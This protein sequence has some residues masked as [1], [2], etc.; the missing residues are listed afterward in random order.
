VHSFLSSYSEEGL[1]K[2]HPKVRNIICSTIKLQ[3]PRKLSFST[4]LR[5][6]QG[7]PVITVRAADEATRHRYARSTISEYAALARIASKAIQEY[8]TASRRSAKRRAAAA[9]QA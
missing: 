8:S 6:L 4:L 2:L 3:H 5:I 7:C 9:E 1:C